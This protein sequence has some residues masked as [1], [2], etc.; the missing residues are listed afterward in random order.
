MI[1]I[2]FL[3]MIVLQV[4]VMVEA[5][6][7]LGVSTWTGNSNWIKWSAIQGV[8]GEANVQCEASLKL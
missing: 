7:F 3:H 6:Q 4:G 5:L 8:I 1:N 2:I